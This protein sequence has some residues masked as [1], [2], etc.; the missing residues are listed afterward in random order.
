MVT[1]F[2]L[3]VALFA[4]WTVWGA[5]KWSTST[6]ATDITNAKIFLGLGIGGLSAMALIS[7]L[8]YYIARRNQNQ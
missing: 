5:T 1:F 4:T 6:K 7:G 8:F 3:A 2:G